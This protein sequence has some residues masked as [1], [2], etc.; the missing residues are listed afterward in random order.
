MELSNLKHP[1]IRQVALQA[2]TYINGILGDSWKS[3]WTPWMAATLSSLLTHQTFKDTKRTSILVEVYRFLLS[4]RGDGLDDLNQRLRPLLERDA[5]EAAA[6]TAALP[7]LVLAGA[8]MILAAKAALETS[9]EMI[10][11]EPLTS[12]SALISYLLHL[13][14]A[15]YGLALK[16]EP[17]LALRGPDLHVFATAMSA[18]QG[19]VLNAISA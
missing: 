12:Q 13:G 14:Y 17:T 16:D 3:F 2:M 9:T 18:I 1:M 8:H 15:E 19:Y 5:T 6:A 4:G 7:P 11:N 10:R